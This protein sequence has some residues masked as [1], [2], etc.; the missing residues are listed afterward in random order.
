MASSLAETYRLN[1]QN[2]A[3]RHTFVAFGR[4]DVAVLRDLAP[5]ARSAAGQIATA[6]YDR[7]FSFAPTREFF[8]AYARTAG[9]SLTDLRAGLE[10]AQTVYFTQIFDEAA[11]SG[12]F[13]LDYFERRLAVGRLHN[14]INLPIKWY[15]G[16]YPS[17]L[18][19]FRERLAQQYPKDLGLR[20]RA[21]RALGIVFN[22][23]MQAVVE[24]FYF[25]TFVAMGVRLSGVTVERGDRDLS[26]R[27]DALKAMVKVPLEAIAGTLASLKQTSSAMTTNA[28]QVGRAIEETASA[29]AE[30]AAGAE[31]Q[32]KLVEDA[33]RVAEQ[34][35]QAAGESQASV[36]EGTA[37]AS[38]AT[39]VMRSVAESSSAITAAMGRL[40]AQ[41]EQ[42]GAIVDT[43]NGI[44]DQTNLLALNAAIEAARAGEQGRGFAVVA[45]EVRKL[46]E[47]SKTA[48]GTI[49]SIIDEIRTETQAAVEVATE[50]ARRTEQGAAVVQR[51]QEAFGAIAEQVADISLRVTEILTATDGVAS[52]AE[53]S[54]ASAEQVSAST[55]QTTASTQEFAGTARE[56]DDAARSL[57]EIV[58]AFELHIAARS[59]CASRSGSTRKLHSTIRPSVIVKAPIEKGLPSLTDTSAGGAVDERTADREP[60]AGPHR[61]LAGDRLRAV[62]SVR[63]P[64]QPS[65]GPE[66]DIG[67]EHRDE[68]L[69]VAAARRGQE[70]VHDLPLFGERGVRDRRGGAH[71][72]AGAAGQLPGRRGRAVDDRGDLLERHREHVM[73]DERQPLGRAQRFEHHQQRQA[74]RVREQRLVLG[75]D[76]VGGVHD[77][78]REMDA[79]VCSCRTARERS[80]FSATRATIVVSHAPRFSTTPLSA[81]LAR[82][83]ASWTASSAS[84]TDPSIL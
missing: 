66:H 31:N 28:E 77:R 52:V 64:G 27:G 70:R 62:G 34:T 72:P 12:R 51:S 73:Q 5:W 4:D 18:D 79:I 14:A 47:G 80:M 9:R 46:A 44:A 38:Q 7:Q 6:F 45:D 36:S 39:E 60:G 21:E 25:D 37:A 43:I 76:A 61:R 17:Y 48:A 59:S 78:V 20:V 75:V 71:P 84:L 23:D 58:A 15:L 10:R 2:I 65:V 29:I 69:E 30:I 13:G 33:R 11:A 82:S 32:V 35:A 81:L 67:G 16:S 68:R 8:E 49:R 63:E 42:I 55:E 56:L 54:S 50:G 57:E 74:D 26:D 19:L 83:Q 3:L 1:E 40:V 41:S 22:L 53:Q 24:A